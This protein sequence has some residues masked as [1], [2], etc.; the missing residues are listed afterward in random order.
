M[1]Q[2]TSTV[3]KH[4][5]L[6]LDGNRR[7]ATEAGLPK[8]EGH[9]RGYENLKT[10]GRHAI[11]ER[12]VEFVSAYVFSTENWNRS[13]EEVGYLMDLLLWV[14]TKEVNELHA[15]NI[16][17]RFMGSR[18]RLSDKH[19]RA[20]DASEEKT[21]NNTAGT[22]ALCMNYGGQQEIAD[23][24][25]EIIRAGIPAESVGPETIAGHLYAPEIP[26]VDFMIRSS[27]EQ[28]ISNFMLWRVAYAEFKF[29]DKHWPAFT[30]NDLD[31]A[32]ADYASRQRRFGK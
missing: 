8:L 3:P 15:D 6:I 32:L 10:I 27:G 7:W 17:V 30:V 18:G 21:K 5:G 20:I 4:L 1:N 13:E 11:L 31:E 24:V 2:P 19:L 23:A 16:R 14:A 26:A 9:R 12:G 29:V 25:K 28:R 22:L